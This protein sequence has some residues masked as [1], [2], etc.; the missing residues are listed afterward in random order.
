MKHYYDQIFWV[1]ATYAPSTL[2]EDDNR[3]NMKLKY[4]N[5]IIL[6]LSIH[7][8][9]TFPFMIHVRNLGVFSRICSWIVLHTMMEL[10]ISWWYMCLILVPILNFGL[11]HVMPHHLAS[12]DLGSYLYPVDI[13]SHKIVNSIP[14][15]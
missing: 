9:L 15:I 12:T 5:H 10:T 11:L 2:D 14:C 7:G 13:N 1:F 4:L 3:G 6:M 8:R